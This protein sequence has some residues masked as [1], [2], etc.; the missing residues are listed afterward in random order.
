MWFKEIKDHEP[1][2]KP[3][4][5]VWPDLKGYFAKRKRKVDKIIFTSIHYRYILDLDKITSNV[6]LPKK[7]EKS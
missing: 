2:L 4:L 6:K 3:A 7:P 1:L 5:D